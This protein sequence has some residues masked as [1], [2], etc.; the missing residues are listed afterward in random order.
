MMNLFLDIIWSGFLAARQKLLKVGIR[1]T[2]KGPGT[3]PQQ[4]SC[5]APTTDA[6]VAINM[7]AR[8]PHI[9]VS[10]DQIQSSKRECPNPV[11]GPWQHQI[12]LKKDRVVQGDHYLLLIPLIIEDNTKR[13]QRV[14]REGQELVTDGQIIKNAYHK[15]LKFIGLQSLPK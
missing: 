10:L 9:F 4:K 7:T 8:C 12:W 5:N 11:V 15:I 14:Y 13:D 3:E 2:P 6:A 1:G